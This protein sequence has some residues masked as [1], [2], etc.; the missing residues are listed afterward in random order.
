[1]GFGRLFAPR[2]TDTDVFYEGEFVRQAGCKGV[3]MIESFVGDCAWV[4]WGDKR[5]LLPLQC[6]RRTKPRG[7]WFDSPRRGRGE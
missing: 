7:E 5:D 1:M 4:V 2:R 6:L 3:G